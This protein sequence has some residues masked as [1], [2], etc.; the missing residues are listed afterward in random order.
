MPR[1]A[2]AEEDIVAFRRRAVDAAVH[3]FAAQGYAAVTMRSL[4]AALGVSTMTT[5]RYIAGKDEL[6]VLVRAEAF[7][8]F[9]DALVLALAAAPPGDPVAR[10]FALK[11]AYIAFAVA[12]PDAYR[13]MFELRGAE[14]PKGP[15]RDELA[16]QS[17][18]AFACLHG[19]VVD[20]VA[21]GYLQGDPLTHAHLFWA[22]THGLC[23]LHLAGQLSEARLQVLARELWELGA[24]IAS[25]SQKRALQPGNDASERQKMP[26]QS[27]QPAKRPSAR[28]RK[29]STRKRRIR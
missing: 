12:Q 4:G 13:S 6:F 19:C 21:H 11:R 1:S 27:P 16:A 7:R 29:K 28:P 18:R 5:Y 23:S 17:R 10:L 9:A 22:S 25:A 20:A 2:L 15:A 14:P 3:L 8:R 24:S 26:R